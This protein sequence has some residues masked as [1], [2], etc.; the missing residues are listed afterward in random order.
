MSTPDPLRVLVFGT[1]D[2][3]VHPRVAV[4]IEGLRAHGVDVRE[5]NA[6]LGLNTAARVRMLRRPWTLPLL[7]ARL[8]S[9]W[10]VLARQARRMLA[11]DGSA[12]SGGRG[13]GGWR[14]DAVLVGYLGHFDVLLARLL[15]GRLGV[16]VVLDHLVFAADTARDRG[17]GLTLLQ[18]ALRRLDRAALRCA[19]V[20]L[21]DTEEHRLQVPA[22]L[23]GRALVVPVGA[24][25]AWFRTTC[26][27]ASD[28]GADTGADTDPRPAT[29]PLTV[30][31]FGLF[32]PLQGA[33]VIGAALAAVP[34]PLAVTLVGGGQDEDATRAA[35][36]D[37]RSRHEVTWLPWV[38]AEQLPA[39]VA[40][41]DVCLGIFGDTPKARNVVPTKV[42]QGAAAGCALV[43]GDTPPQRRLLEGSAEL[44][45]VADPGALA[46]VLTALAVDPRRVA[47]LR[48]A[49]RA[50]AATC[51]D[52]A[53]VVAPLLSAVTELA[54]R[55]DPAAQ[56]AVR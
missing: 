10:V 11:G 24:G 46:E 23:R 38:P 6:V 45:P 41:H 27:P 32:T 14:P 51:A 2:A 12:S 48:S 30:I 15:F 36:A 25:S 52:P 20:V 22:S 34:E 44:V 55:A 56:G 28:T 16:P 9:R 40:A 1:Y 42:Y 35:L 19:Q 5:C 7:A 13:S 4:L 33:P 54:G 18:L 53:A 31:F 21:V 37:S 8:L 17:Q 29:G 39:M 26:S 50:L 3:S 49:S 43:T 47:R